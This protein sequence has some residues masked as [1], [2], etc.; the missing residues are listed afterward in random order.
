MT[1]KKALRSRTS[2]VPVMTRGREQKWS[3]ASRSTS[4]CLFVVLAMMNIAEK[5]TNSWLPVTS[6]SRIWRKRRPWILSKSSWLSWPYKLVVNCKMERQSSWQLQSIRRQEQICRKKVKN[7]TVEV[8]WQCARAILR[9][10]R[11]WLLE[12]QKLDVMQKTQIYHSKMWKKRIKTWITTRFSSK[13]ILTYWC[14]KEQSHRSSI[15]KTRGK[16]TTSVWPKA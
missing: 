3:F 2:H 11:R 16:L 9:S 6:L 10:K 1:L 5:F 7:G 15:N 12:A 8:M 13:K 14:G 4:M